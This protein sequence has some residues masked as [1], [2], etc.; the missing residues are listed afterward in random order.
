MALRKQRTLDISLDAPNAVTVVDDIHINIR[1]RKITIHFSIYA[2]AQAHGEGRQRI[3]GDGWDFPDYPAVLD[4]EGVEVTPA[5]PYYTNFLAAL[6][7][8]TSPQRAAYNLL[9]THP[10]FEDAEEV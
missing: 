4:S 1:E 7:A 8:R 3:G 6:A 9:K 10:D 2:T 5:R